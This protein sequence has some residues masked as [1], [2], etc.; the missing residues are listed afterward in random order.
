MI[1]YH[2]WYK[3][4]KKGDCHIEDEDGDHFKECEL[5]FDLLSHFSDRYNIDAMLDSKENFNQDVYFIIE[6]IKTKGLK[7]V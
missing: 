6:A 4:Y 2:D 3:E 1:D 5:A 7:N